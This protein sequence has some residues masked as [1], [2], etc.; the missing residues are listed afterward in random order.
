MTEF[1]RSAALRAFFARY[2]AAEGRARDPRIEQA[3]AAVDRERFVGPSPWSINIP[4]VGYIRTPNDDL[5]FIYQDT[6]VALDAG[7]GINIGRPSAHACWL[8]ALAL[9]EGET[10]VQI[11]AGTGYYTALLA[12]LVGPRGY[13]HAY[14]IDPVLSARAGQNLAHMPWV[15]VHDRSGIADDLPKADAV[16]VNAGITQPCW[17]WL[18]AIKVGGRLLFPLHAEG[19]AGGMLWIGKPKRGTIWPARFVSEAAFISCVGNQSSETGRR[20]NVAFKDGGTESVQS[21]RI[22]EAIDDTCWFAGDGWW[23]STSAAPVP[24]LATELRFKLD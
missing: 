1:D 3:F 9:R 6:L 2:V 7:R 12:H 16:Y 19:G 23:L 5:A 21:F 20:L 15:T 22:D 4:G 8:D 14:E 10:V 13:V 24:P 17:C 11:G 18:D